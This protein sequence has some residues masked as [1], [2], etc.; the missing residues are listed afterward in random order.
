MSATAISPLSRESKILRPP[1]SETSA[2]DS[3]VSETS[4]QDLAK[5][6]YALWE[7]RGCPYGSPDQDWFEAEH[8]LR[9]SSELI[10]R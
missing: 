4:M 2:S 8:R 1:G 9:E 7:E 3:H 10:A 5:L 6:A